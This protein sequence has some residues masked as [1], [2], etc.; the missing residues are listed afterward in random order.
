MK[1]F[2]DTVAVEAVAGG[3][4]VVLDGRPIKTAVGAP[5]IVPSAPLAQALAH[6]WRSQGADIDASAFVLRDMADF[7]IDIAR[8]DRD[9]VIAALLAYAGSDTL[10]YRAE[11]DEPLAIRQRAVWEPLLAAAEERW[12]VAFTRV[13]GIIHR[14]QP[15]ATLKAMRAALTEQDDFTLAALNTLAS[16]AASLVIALAAAEPG[17]DAAALWDAANLEE[18]WQAEQ[19]GVDDEA[20]ALRTRRAALFG[21]AM[22]FAALLRREP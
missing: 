9:A 16:L 15:P 14:A 18:D 4:R 13:S 12:S 11:P 5:Q 22:R 10:C 1:R 17:A 7:A 3:W 6:E 2:W 8:T 19:W 21:D 20:L